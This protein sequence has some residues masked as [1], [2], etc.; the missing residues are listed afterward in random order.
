[1]P[2]TRTRP[3]LLV[4]SVPLDSSSAVFEAVADSLDGLAKRIP[5]GETKERK[6]WIGWQADVMKNAKGLEPGGSREIQGGYRFTLYKVKNA[7]DIEIGP[8]GYAVAALK[9]Y[10]DFKRLRA[11]GRI[12]AGTRFQVSL[13]TPIAVV[14][15]FCEPEAIGPVWPKYEERIKQEVDEI[16]RAI[17]H[18][19]LAIQW[20][21]AVEI[22]FVLEVPEVAK[23]IPM[24]AL[25]ASIARIS[26]PVPADVELGLHL[27][28][29]DPGHKHV[30][31]PKDTGLMVEFAN[32]LSSEIK[33][34]IAWLHLPVPRDRDD[35]AYFTPLRGLKLHRDTELY[36]GLVHLTDGVAG[37]RRRLDAATQVVS[38]FGIATEC[39]FGR[40][41][42]ETVS[43]LLEL[44]RAVAHAG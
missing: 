19:D 16:T 4:G 22:C 33:R 40:R 1:M 41:P 31:E 34:P 6:D 25:V 11:Q 32:R 12:G 24:E 3:V 15:S 26:E 5:D 8:L 39:G 13:P 38:D 7:A 20:D 37:A 29:G 18:R 28:Y 10:E 23:V 17:P 44:H 36:L 21:I 14:M 30:V 42:P 2:D 43:A 35:V 9:S 27:C